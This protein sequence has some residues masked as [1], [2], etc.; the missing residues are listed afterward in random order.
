MLVTVLLADYTPQA[1]C[2]ITRFVL[3][4]LREEVLG[5]GLF[6]LHRIFLILLLCIQ[7]YNR[8]YKAGTKRLDLEYIKLYWG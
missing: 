4:A 8:K 3:K 7:F 5:Q 2:A 6:W 1:V